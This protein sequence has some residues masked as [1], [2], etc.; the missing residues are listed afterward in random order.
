MN[1]QGW[2]KTHRARLFHAFYGSHQS[3]C[4]RAYFDED[5][6]LWDAPPHEEPMCDRCFLRLA[7][8]HSED[9][10]GIK[11]PEIIFIPSQSSKLKTQGDETSG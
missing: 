4:A 10:L 9:I 2:A 3:L 5:R 7:L 1:P 8:A 11:E 6:E